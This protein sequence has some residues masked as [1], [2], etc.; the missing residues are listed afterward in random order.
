[1]R[2]IKIAAL[3]LSAVLTISCLSGCIK[4]KSGSSSSEAYFTR[5][6]IE[7]LTF[8]EV[9]ELNS[10]SKLGDYSLLEPLP[11]PM[12]IPGGGVMNKGEDEFDCYPY[13]G[14]NYITRIFLSST[15]TNVFGI[16]NGQTEADADDKLQN[17]GYKKLT[18][19]DASRFF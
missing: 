2:T 10:N 16:S 3:V 8:E 4:A 12:Q 7:E 11:Y 15:D 9:N 1:M 5:N 13:A 18:A 19:D 17:K 6:K 14:E